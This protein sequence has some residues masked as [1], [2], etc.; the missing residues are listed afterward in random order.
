MKTRRTSFY[1]DAVTMA[2]QSVLA[3]KLRSFL[4]LIGIII[5][6]ASVVV[7]GASIS[8]MNSY[9][10]ER[11]S[12][13]LGIN[14]FLMARM[15]GTGNITEE[16]WQRMDRR[17]KRLEWDDFD[18]VVR[19]CPSCDEVGAQL[20]TRVDLKRG[21][22]ELIGVQVAGVTANMARIED[23]SMGEGRFILPHEVENPALVCVLGAEIKDKLFEGVE[24][25]GRTLRV[26]GIEMRVVGVEERRGSM[27]GQSLDRHIYLPI[28]TFE[29]TFGRRQ[30]L[31]IHGLGA[32]REAFLVALDEAHV[33][34]RVHHKLKGN[35][36]DD[37]GLVNVEEVNQ[38]VDQ[39]TG[40]IAMVVTPITLI[41][42]VV[43]GIVVMNIMLVTVNERTFEIGLRK[44]VGA[45]KREIMVQFLIESALLCGLGGVLG[46]LL[47]AGVSGAIR[48]FSG[49][50]MVVTIGYVVLALAGVE[51]RRNPGRD[52]PCLQGG[53]ARPRGCPHPKLMHPSRSALLLDTW[54]M[55]FENL[56]AHRLR[57]GLTVFGVVIGVLVVVVV[58]SILT[59]MRRNII[60]AVE[61]YGTNNIFAFHLTT[62]PQLGDRDRAEYR[63]KPLRPED[64]EAILAQA[65]AVEEVANLGFLW[66]RDRTMSYGREKYQRAQLQAVS[67]NYLSVTGLSLR[68][69]RFFTETDD[70]GRREV[71][72]IG[73][74]RG[75][76]AVWRPQPRWT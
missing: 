48:A 49:I 65:P 52:L 6:V 24:P 13:V 3:H 33:G 61:E 21:H 59:G 54:R 29:R 46:L 40:A 2:L 1:Q 43:G 8:G 7:V 25:L 11:V 56:R 68:E 18:A 15:A 23:K 66:L 19:R 34:L 58:A 76:R 22:D 51:H 45:R 50:P 67:A 63:R 39:F 53:Q 4:T 17:N 44:A 5:G 37:F 30:S 72:V 55:A 62:G 57:S 9:V 26:K 71:M 41:S 60:Q 38:N 12:K 20:N 74:G 69:G 64:G 31:Q 70:R 10:V 75:R 47:A 14:H 32:S 36:E 16:Q 35:E 27:F 73:D 28:T 42:L